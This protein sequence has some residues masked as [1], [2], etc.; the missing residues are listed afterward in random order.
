[1]NKIKEEE[2]EQIRN[3]QQ[4]L[5]EILNSIGYLE[6]Q[7]HALLHRI[8]QVNE[9]EVEIKQRLEEEYG[10]INI[11]IEDGTYTTIEENVEENVE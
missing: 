1:M 2:L 9:D 5:N 4:E 11:N 3:T 7:K 8:K 6:S 10:S